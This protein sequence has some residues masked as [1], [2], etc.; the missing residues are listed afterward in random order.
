MT[1]LA[2]NLTD[3]IYAVNILDQTNT[4]GFTSNS[5]G[6]PRTYGVEL[7]YRFGASAGH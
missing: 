7:R 6:D 5:Y 1:N 2:K 3:T 4:F